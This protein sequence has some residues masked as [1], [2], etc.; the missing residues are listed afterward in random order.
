MF[1][2]AGGEKSR[3]RL[4]TLCGTN[5]GFA[6]AEADLLQRGPGDFFGSRQHGI[7]ASRFYEMAAEGDVILDA[8]QAVDE[9]LSADPTLDDPENAP[10]R[11]RVDAVFSDAEGTI[12]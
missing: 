6:I 4:Q 7:P 12:N 11:G 3:E 10:L 8:R 9:V 1:E 2:G 5:D